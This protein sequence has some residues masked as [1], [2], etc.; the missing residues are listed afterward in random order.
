MHMGRTYQP[1][2]KLMLV[3]DDGRAEGGTVREQLECE[4]GGDVVGDVRHTQVKVGQL[5]FHEVAVDDLCVCVCVGGGGG[6]G[7]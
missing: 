3:H 2:G 7:G 6:G 4:R 5:N 1:H